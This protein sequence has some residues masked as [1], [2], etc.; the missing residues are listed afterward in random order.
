MTP[1]YFTFGS[2]KGFP[3]QNAYLIVM[4]ETEVEAVK[5]FRSRYKDRTPDVANCSFWYARD[6]WLDLKMDISKFDPKDIIG[7]CASG[8]LT[9]DDIYVLAED[10]A[11]G[12]TELDRKDT[13]RWEVDIYAR[14]NGLPDPEEAEI[15]EDAIE[16]ICD[17][18]NLEFTPDG[19]LAA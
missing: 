8:N 18:W 15:P 9:W 4:A 10:S 12:S 7:S 1:F 17:K 6:K 14:I 5:K 3:Y 16:D 19:Y 2:D 13:A 11:C